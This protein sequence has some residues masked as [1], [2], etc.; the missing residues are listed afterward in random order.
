MMKMEDDT[1]VQPRAARSGRA[2]WHSRER[3]KSCVLS[4]E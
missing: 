4:W 1:K 3:D 2:T